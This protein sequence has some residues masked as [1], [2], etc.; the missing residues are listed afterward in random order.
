MSNYTTNLSSFSYL[1]FNLKNAQNMKSQNLESYDSNSSCD[2]SFTEEQY[3]S[4]TSSCTSSQLNSPNFT[5]K[6]SDISNKLNKDALLLDTVDDITDLMED[7]KIY[8][9]PP[10]QISNKH[11]FTPPKKKPEKIN[12]DAM[13]TD[14]QN[15]SLVLGRSIQKGGKRL[16][17]AVYNALPE[18]IKLKTQLNVRHTDEFNNYIIE[19]DMLYINPKKKSVISFEIKGVNEKTI[20][21]RDRQQKLIDQCLKQKE[22]LQQYYLNYTIKTIL[23]FVTG[24]TNNDVIDERFI[25]IIRGNGIYVCTGKTPHRLANNALTELFK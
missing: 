18:N 13:V 3:N 24:Y 1:N 9:T 12:Y 2:T 23:C 4:Y 17:Q 16:E 22:Y 14:E 7:E 25:A 21:D 19:F 11:I 8:S 5:Y 20:N 6:I 15:E 10:K